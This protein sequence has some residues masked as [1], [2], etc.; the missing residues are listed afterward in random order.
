M[1]QHSR[2]L[3]TRCQ[4]FP[5]PRVVAIKTVS[6]HSQCLLGEQ[7]CSYLKRTELERGPAWYFLEQ[8]ITKIC[9]FLTCHKNKQLFTGPSTVHTLRTHKHL[10]TDLLI[11]WLIICLKF[12]KIKEHKYVDEV[13]MRG[14][15]HSVRN[16]SSWKSGIMYN[17]STSYSPNMVFHIKICSFTWSLELPFQVH[18]K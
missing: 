10:W 12:N 5:F 14:M 18:C 15:E 9:V 6:E 17:V 2:L 3:S 1:E 4:Q 16:R 8:E 13:V 7:N 11:G